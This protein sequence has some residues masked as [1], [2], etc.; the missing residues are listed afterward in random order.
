M[1]AISRYI[2]ML[3]FVVALSVP[4]FSAGAADVAWQL[5]PTHSSVEFTVRHLGIS[6]VNGSFGVFSA[7]VMADEKTG[8]L[9]SVQAEADVDSVNTGVEKRDD[10]LKSPEFFD[11][12]K[13]PKMYLKTKKISWK[14]D[15]IT[16]IADLT[17]KGITRTVEF[18]GEYL[19]S[20]KANFGTPQLRAGY[21]LKGV[22]NRQN[23]GLSF[24]ALA[25]GVAIVGDKVT[26]ELDLEIARNL[27]K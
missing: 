4:S 2:T 12:K 19:G 1:K 7:T 20:Q 5:D 14:G 27:K 9:S 18:K 26:I 22:I 17:I 24:N 13:F 21:S 25:E 8:K 3:L 10:H 23:F 11:A 15:Q 6:K 16:V